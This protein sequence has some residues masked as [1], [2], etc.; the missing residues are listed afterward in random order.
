MYLS[1]FAMHET[2]MEKGRVN[3]KQVDVQLFRLT[4]HAQCMCKYMESIN[5]DENRRVMEDG[6][7]IFFT[8]LDR[9]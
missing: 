1:D 2:K 9:R 8:V 4:K 6:N 3:H 5:I 7:F